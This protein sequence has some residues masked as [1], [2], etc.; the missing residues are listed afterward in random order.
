VA[1]RLLTLVFSVY[2][3]I[4]IC[5]TGVHMAAEYLD[6]KTDVRQGLQA[7]AQT[8]NQGLATAIYNVD[9]EQVE[10]MVGGM[11]A[12]PSVVGV[13]VATEYQGAFRAG[14]TDPAAEGRT[15]VRDLEKSES[16]TAGGA[17]WISRP[18]IYSEPG[19]QAY[20][21]GS[22]RLYSHRNVV[23]GKV[24]YG[25]MFILVNSVIKTAALW[26][27][28]LWFSRTRLLRPLAELTA[29]TTRVDPDDPAPRRVTVSTRGRNE[30]TVLQDAYNAMLD[31]LF[32]AR[33]RSRALTENLRLAH[34]ELE[35]YSRTL[36]Q[37]VAERT[38]ALDRQNERLEE[39]VRQLR[40]A[41]EAAEAATR[42]KSEFLAS[43][44]HEIRTP[45]NAILGM[46]ELLGDTDL[47]HE[48]RECVRVFRSAG[49]NLLHI[50]DDILDLSKVESGLLELESIPLDPAALV[51]DVC[52]VAGVQAGAKGLRLEWDAAPGVPRRV[53]G[54]PTRLRQ[55]LQNLLANAVKFT[56]QG[57][58]VV[59][60]I[61]GPEPDSLDFS[62]ADTGV[63]IPEDKQEAVF[64]SFTQADSSTTRR[65]GGTGLGLTIS[66]SLVERMGGAMELRSAPGRGTTVRFTAR[67]P[68][69]P[70]EPARAADARDDRA[71]ERLRPLRVLLA[72]DHVHNQR[73]MEMILDRAGHR[74]DLAENGRE[75]VE[76]FAAGRYDVVLMDMEMPEMDGYQ[77]VQRIRALEREQGRARTPVVALTAHAFAEAVRKS[78]EAGCDRHLSKP[79]RRGDLLRLMAELV[80]GDAPSSD[81]SPEVSGPGHEVVLVDADLLPLAEDFVAASRMDVSRMRQALDMDDL[82]RVRGLAHA[83]K[84]AGGGLGLHRVSEL[85]RSVELAAAANDADAARAGQEALERHLDG[86]RPASRPA[87]E[88]SAPG[89]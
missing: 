11:V 85:A 34:D 52:R 6:T 18:I 9:R 5:L 78:L 82:E 2:V 61:P 84:G 42:A 19:G 75:A 30:L 15:P 69:A 53:L 89:P 80:D 59:R 46:A 54:D 25:F 24:W 41:K 68:A 76:R 73:L 26:I 64:Q 23:L 50:I 21:I 66:R 17:F 13:H 74:M 3:L 32:Q 65:Y 39:T 33:G 83:M 77:A 49:E 38:H 14:R 79:L 16:G 47:D 7:M 37:K 81:V 45:M 87:P 48:Q 56:E 28:F 72:E 4:T 44:S 63:G 55:V 58:I 10:S 29:A 36:E 40:E 12:N 88:S 62:V 43:M 60:V 20:A 35:E 31:K 8:V 57:D 1:T 86:L 51:E 27:I 71:M 67:L 22:L 70:A